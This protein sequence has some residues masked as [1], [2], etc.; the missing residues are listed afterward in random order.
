MNP[1]PKPGLKTKRPRKPITRKPVSPFVAPKLDFEKRVPIRKSNPERQRW[2]HVRNF[3]GGIGHDEFVRSKGCAMERLDECNGIVQA[4]H[5]VKPRGAG[6]IWTGIVG[7]CDKH[8]RIQE[9][10]GC[11]RVKTAT[12]ID[13]IF[14]AKTMVLLNLQSK[15]A[16]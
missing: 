2:L 6:G 5:V 15:D 13:L 1:I 9:S 10:Q 14:T 4:A 16:I 11:E 8:H 12:G 7:L 3:D